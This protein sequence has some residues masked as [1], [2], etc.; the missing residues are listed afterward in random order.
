MGNHATRGDLLRRRLSRADMSRHDNK[1]YNIG[2]VKLPIVRSSSLERCTAK[3][4]ATLATVEPAALRP[5]Q[6]ERLK[7]QFAPNSTRDQ[8]STIW[9][10]CSRSEL[11]AVLEAALIESLTAVVSSNLERPA[12]SDL[13]KVRDMYATLQQLLQAFALRLAVERP[14]LVRSEF[15]RLGWQINSQPHVWHEQ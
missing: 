5:N 10:E 3:V 8:H 9:K 14:D 13:R 2:E 1:H 15:T 7:A 4:V 6:A 12:T 11:G